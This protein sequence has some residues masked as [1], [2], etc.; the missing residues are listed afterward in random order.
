MRRLRFITLLAGAAAILF[1]FWQL[2]Q[3]RSHSG[4][5]EI[6]SF[7]GEGRSIDEPPFP[8]T[9]TVN[10]P[11][12]IHVECSDTFGA[13]VRTSNGEVEGLIGIGDRPGSFHSPRP[14]TYH[15]RISTRGTWTAR[16]V[17]VS[18]PDERYYG[19]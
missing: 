11:W 19:R 16:V 8:N 2:M 4:E 9:F 1:V 13:T 3:M 5:R 12:E 7:S 6:A 10:G 15:L 17:E 14:G 18:N